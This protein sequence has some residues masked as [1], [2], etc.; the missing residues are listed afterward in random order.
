M[1]SAH[2]PIFGSTEQAEIERER[3]SKHV[4][5]KII[6]IFIGFYRWYVVW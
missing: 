1:L 5:M 3:K 2:R 4:E 6:C